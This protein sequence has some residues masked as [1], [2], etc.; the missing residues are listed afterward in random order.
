MRLSV[1]EALQF[2]IWIGD[3]VFIFQVFTVYSFNLPSDISAGHVAINTYFHGNATVEL[4]QHTRALCFFHYPPHVADIISG[5][6]AHFEDNYNLS[7]SLVVDD[8]A[9]RCKQVE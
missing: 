5:F 3:C 8:W 4:F 1:L 6:I 9:L 2:T 7:M